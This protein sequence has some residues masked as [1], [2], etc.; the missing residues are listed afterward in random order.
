MIHI[1]YIIYMLRAVPGTPPEWLRYV[2]IYTYGKLIVIRQKI[3]NKIP[4]ELVKIYF[5]IFL[6]VTIY[7]YTRIIFSCHI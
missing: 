1:I 3:E 7:I 5:S 6:D 4:I 2:Y